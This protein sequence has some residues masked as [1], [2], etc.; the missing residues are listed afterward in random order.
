MVVRA[1]SDAQ[2]FFPFS[3]I[4]TLA[5]IGPAEPSCT[6]ATEW[7]DNELATESSGGGVQSFAAGWVADL[8][9]GRRVPPQRNRGR[10]GIA[11]VAGP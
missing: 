5:D 4:S 1:R 10:P 9:R 7:S 8:R 6:S 2:A 3:V 11:G